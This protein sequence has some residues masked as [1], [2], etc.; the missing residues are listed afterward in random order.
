MANLRTYDAFIQRL[1]NG[2]GKLQPLWGEQTTAPV[3]LGGNTETLSRGAWT[4]VLPSLPSGV[5]AF[6]PTLFMGSSS[7]APVAVLLARLTNLGDLNIATPTFTDG[8]AMPT[9]TEGGVSRVT[10]GAIL[11]EV[12]T[13]LN[14]TPGNLQVTYVDQDGNTAEQTAT[15]SLG[16]SAPVGSAGW[17]ALNS[18]DYGARDV[19]TAT[20]T[21]GTSPTGIVRLWGIY[22]LDLVAASAVGAAGSIGATFLEDFLAAGNYLQLAAGDVLGAFVI[23]ASNTTRALLGTLGMVGDST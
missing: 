3:P 9:L 12:T 10:D 17:I 8:S 11:L 4:R 7:T 1:S 13:V 2:Y 21:G 15:Q 22:P 19:T 6:L 14:A 23:G 18:P 20:R 16:A 5:S